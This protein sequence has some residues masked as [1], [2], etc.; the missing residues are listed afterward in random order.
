MYYICK[1][2][3]FAAAHRIRE[4]GGDCENIHGHNWRIRAT[5]AARKLSH[6]GMAMDFKELKGLLI[7]ILGALDH[8][9]LNAVPPF[10]AINPTS[11]NIARWLSEKLTARLPSPD[12]KVSRIE[13]WETETSCA[14]FEPD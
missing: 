8:K 5:V 1:E 14:A 11:E 7:D 13:V 3:S 6:L 10:D 12:V 4:H 9:D 2:V